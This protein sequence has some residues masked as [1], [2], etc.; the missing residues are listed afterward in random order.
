M[1]KIN[2]KKAAMFGLDARIALAIFGA[3]SVIS[4]A[5]LYSAIQ[6]A[7]GTKL[8]ADMQEIGKAWEQYYL[9]T[10]ENLEKQKTDNLNAYS[11]IYKSRALVENPGVTGWKGPY[12]SY[13][14]T[15][16]V[17][18][19]DH[20]RYYSDDDYSSI[21]LFFTDDGVGDWGGDQ[22][23]GDE[24]WWDKTFC[25]AGKSCSLW[26]SILNLKSLDTAV[27]ADKVIDGGDGPAKGNL[28]WLNSV[29][30][31]WPHRVYLRYSGIQ[32]PN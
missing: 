13:T 4:G 30:P 8:L 17:G 29:S 7:Q 28:R 5:A 24:T 19:L 1:K 11:Y 27:A 26:V 2:L 21:R 14:T 6:Q 12:L 31:T 23:D 18:V 15:N 10:G 9:D 32:N 20:L 22:N 25:T 16:T 3:L